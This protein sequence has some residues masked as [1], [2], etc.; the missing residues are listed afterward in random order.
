MTGAWYLYIH[1]LDY[2][3]DE[4]ILAFVAYA[5][6]GAFYL[7]LELFGDAVELAV[8]LVC[9]HV[10]ESPAEYICFPDAVRV[11]LKFVVEVFYEIFAL[12]F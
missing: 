10:I 4:V 3:T 12:A 7:E 2:Y 9:Y 11:L 8:Y 6:E 5:L 1:S